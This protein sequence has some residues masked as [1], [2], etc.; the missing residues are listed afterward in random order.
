MA[1]VPVLEFF[2]DIVCPF[3]YV[4]SV[5]LRSLRAPGGVRIVPVPVLLGG[6]Y[7]L[8]AAPQ[9]K[10]AS[11]TSAMNMRKSSFVARD[12]QRTAER[13]RVKISYHP[14]HPVRSVDALRM[15]HAVSDPDD[16]MRLA[17]ALF[18]AYWIENVNVADHAVLLEIARKVLGSLPFDANSVFTDRR[19]ADAL[20]EATSRAVSLGAPGVPYFHLPATVVGTPTSFWG[21]DRLHFVEWELLKLSNN[22]AHVAPLPQL[23]LGSGNITTLPPV[24]QQLMMKDMSDWLEYWSALMPV[25]EKP[26]TLTW[27]TKF[28]INSVPAAR[29]VIKHRLA[30]SALFDA[31]WRDSRDISD[32]QV[33]AEVVAEAARKAL[34][35]S[36]TEQELSAFLNKGDAEAAKQQLWENGRRASRAGCFGVPSF[37]VCECQ[38]N[39]LAGCE[40][41]GAGLVWGQ[42]RI[43]DVLVDILAGMEM[44]AGAVPMAGKL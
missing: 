29:A 22:D 7:G 3:A 41:G 42:D 1:P 5:R 30:A 15:L 23:R 8:T 9:G 4:A 37:V 6:I 33:V 21:G 44:G 18:R 25:P 27:P 35:D 38:H 36:A 16:R 19:H 13:F 12:L 32:A 43:M 40:C 2:F 17:D 39:G 26:Y 10:H 34:G 31:A 28:P 24:K 14:N 11:A 20:T